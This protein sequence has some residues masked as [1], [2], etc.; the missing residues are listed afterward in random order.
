M[1]QQIPPLDPLRRW[2]E[3]TS[4]HT[5]VYHGWAPGGKL[6]SII[7]LSGPGVAILW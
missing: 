4:P 1:F 5:F 7:L 3:G 2:G 6:A